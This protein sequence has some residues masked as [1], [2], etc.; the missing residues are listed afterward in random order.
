MVTKTTSCTIESNF[1]S[2]Y[3]PDRKENE[4]HH[5][6]DVF[7]VLFVPM[8]R[9]RPTKIRMPVSQLYLKLRIMHKKGRFHDTPLQIKHVH[10]I[11]SC[12]IDI[13][14]K[15]HPWRTKAKNKVKRPRPY[16]LK[17]GKKKHGKKHDFGVI[18]V[19][20]H[21]GRRTRMTSSVIQ[22]Q[23]KSRILHKKRCQWPTS[24]MCTSMPRA[25]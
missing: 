3:I 9:T 15:L 16:A 23:A 14:V 5:I 2:P 1:W 10:R 17:A 19:S 6:H 25:L 12:A 8:C 7:S 11:A 13:H 20:L 4:K 22:L 24:R 21:K 18:C